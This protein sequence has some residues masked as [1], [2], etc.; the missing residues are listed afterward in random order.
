MSIYNP[1]HKQ[2]YPSNPP[3]S[4]IS[5]YDLSNELKIKILELRYTTNLNLQFYER[6]FFNNVINKIISWGDNA[7]I[8]PY[9]I[10]G[11]NEIYN[12]VFN[13]ADQT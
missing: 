2:D 1:L 3:K 4:Y 8:T 10:R 7:L 9:D 6:C 12:R 5:Y 13:H 11:I